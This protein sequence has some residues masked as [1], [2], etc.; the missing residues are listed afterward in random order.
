[1]V[2]A[3]FS[4]D[5][6]SLLAAGGEELKIWSTSTWR[7]IG[8]QRIPESW[9]MAFSPDRKTLAIGTREKESVCVLWEIAT[10]TQRIVRVGHSAIIHALAFSPDG[11]QLVTGSERYDNIVKFWDLRTLQELAVLTNHTSSI[12]GARF[13]TDGKRLAT[14]S[15][16]QTIRLWDVESKEELAVLR[17][18]DGWV[19]SVA[20][21]PDGKRLLSTCTDG[22]VR[23]W[24]AEPKPPEERSKRFAGLGPWWTLSPD[25]KALFLWP[26]DSTLRV[27]DTATLR[28]SGSHP[29]PPHPS[30]LT[31]WAVS[32]DGKFLAYGDA[33]GE[34]R[35]HD[36]GRGY[37]VTSM[38][39]SAARVVRLTFSSDAALLAVSSADHQIRVW[40]VSNGR[41]KAVFESDPRNLQHS[42]CLAAFVERD[43]W[44][45]FGRGD[46]EL[47]IR[48]LSG[49]G[50][51]RSFTAHNGVIQDIVVSRDGRT[52]ATCSLDKTVK[53]WD[54]TIR[55]PRELATMT[56]RP[57][58]SWH[59]A[60]ALDGARVA[61][62][63]IDGTILL[64]DPR[65]GLELPTLRG[66]SDS[67]VG[68][69]AFLD[70]GDTLVTVQGQTLYVWRAASF[71]ETDNQPAT[72][73]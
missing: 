59:I 72:A 46:G 4:P 11:N 44:L 23:L 67:W 71:K 19:C 24:K 63:P 18:H 65:T 39:G 12:W 50:Q 55:P 21:S 69:M 6:N 54:F 34:I 51:N 62:S 3:A 36:I 10:Q 17:G 14:A 28:E 45:V 70:D 20:F 2:E 22:T 56:C 26:Q 9:F 52:L 48:E 5:G 15:A 27:W 35:V 41:Q 61:A 57:Y 1:V 42:S 25:G 30:S 8:R 29:A 43:R 32:S 66:H 60:V 37:Q 33:D 53:L 68:A 58:P 31:A 73:R 13:S 64:W 49:G 7:E 38:R 16:D 47:E 40:D